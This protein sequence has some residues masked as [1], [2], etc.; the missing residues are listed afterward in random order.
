MNASDCPIQ[1]IQDERLEILHNH[2]IPMPYGPSLS[3]QIGRL[4]KRGFYCCTL[5]VLYMRQ[6]GRS[7]RRSILTVLQAGRMLRQILVRSVWFLGGTCH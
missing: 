1:G 5:T 2:I 4:G 6:Q 3:S 7:D